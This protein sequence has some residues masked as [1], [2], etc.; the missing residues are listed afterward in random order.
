[1][2][3]P[4]FQSIMLPL[5]KYLQD[6]KEHTLREVIEH[7]SKEFNLTDEE[8]MILLPS[9]KQPTIDNR[10]GWARTYMKKAGF[11]LMPS[12]G[13]MKISKKGLEVLQQ[14][15]P[16]INIAYLK[17]SPEFVEFQTMKSEK[18][19]DSAKISE[20]NEDETPDELMERGNKL[21]NSNLIPDV[22][23]ELR[24]CDPYYFEK[25]VGNLLETMGYGD[26]EVTKKSNDGGIDGIVNQDKL[27]ID[28]IFFQAKRYAENNSVTAHEVR[29]FVGTLELSGVN[30]GIFITTSKFP[31]NTQELIRGAQKNIILINGQKL[32]ELMIEYNLGVSI[33]RVYKIKKIDSDFFRED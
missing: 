1:M 7:I 23:S 25:I 27:G 13:Y 26:F 3:V 6:E 9:G 24:S 2:A 21:I 28:K 29:D 8:K 4:D 30:K 32:A 31:S 20:D 22:L 17:K 12:R 33:E 14:N 5:L 16:K 18:V 15:L 19:K 10:V 11:I